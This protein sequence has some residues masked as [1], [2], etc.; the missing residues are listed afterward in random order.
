MQNQTRGMG[1]LPDLPDPRDHKWATSPP[2][3]QALPD[4]VDL[5]ENMPPVVDQL[6]LGSCTANTHCNAVDY[7]RKKQGLSF[8]RG[9]RLFHYFNTRTLEGTVNSDSGASIRNTIKAGVEWGTSFETCWPYDIT[10][11]REKPKQECYDVAIQHQT[12]EY[13]RVE[14]NMQEIMGCLASGFVIQCGIMVY[15]QY[16]QV[17]PSGI[18]NMPNMNEAPLGGH[19]QL[20]CGYYKDTQEGVKVI[21]QNSWGSN[22]GERGYCYIPIGYLTNVQLSGDFWAIK[23][24]E[25]QGPSPTPNIDPWQEHHV[26]P[27]IRRAMEE[28]HDVPAWREDY[29]VNEHGRMVGYSIIHAV[30][31]NEYHYV[32]ASRSNPKGIVTLKYADRIWYVTGA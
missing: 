1:W 18:I 24:T 16:E 17:G 23:L 8:L 32:P 31:G 26:G 21:S 19:S 5:R 27:D 7:Q 9:S 29:A 6:Q 12:L 13:M 20:L 28:M 25:G 30:S 2:I 3:A 4:N 22:W 15:R 14:Q 10:K 11:Y